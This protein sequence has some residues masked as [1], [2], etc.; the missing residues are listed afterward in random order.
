MAIPRSHSYLADGLML[1]AVCL[2]LALTL[3]RGMLSGEST[4]RP[5]RLQAR[6]T[7]AVQWASLLNEGWRIGPD[8]AAV[9]L[10]IFNDYECPGCRALHRSIETLA[11]TYQANAA[12]VYLPYPLSYHRYAASAS[13]AYQCAVDQGRASAMHRVLFAH[14]DSFGRL[15]W[16]TF[17]TKAEVADTG[18]FNQCMA[19]GA[20]SG[21]LEKARQLASTIGVVGT[22]TV[23]INGKR[24][25]RPP[26]AAELD[27]LFLAE[28]AAANVRAVKR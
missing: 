18:S 11:A 1:V 9:T 4:A 23:F 19:G 16:A 17:A 5:A 25:S 24:L 8:S 3:Q 12:Y 2:L 10:A 21:K 6:Q 27:S 20:A 7:S 26:T 15:P 28:L 13:V 22:P 14:S